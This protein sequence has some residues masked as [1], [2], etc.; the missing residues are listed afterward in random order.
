MV[1][2]DLTL[3]GLKK[4]QLLN[5]HYTMLLMRHFEEKAAEG[6]T[7]GKIGGF[8]HLYTG[9]EAVGSGVNLALEQNDVV[10]SSYREHGHALAK[11][12]DPNALMAELYGRASGV[13]KGRGGSM[14]I[15]SKEHKLFGGYAIVAAQLPIACGYA[16]SAK[17]LKEN[18]V[19]VVYFG[20]GA[21]DEGAFH[22]ALNLA[23]VWQ[24]PV[25]F[26]CENNLYSMGMAVERAW[27]VSSLEPRAKAYAMDYEQ[28]NGMNVLDVYQTA[29]KAVKRARETSMPTLIEA[30]TYRFRGHSMAD[31]SSYRSK[32]EAEKWK[33]T[34]DPI[35]LF[36]NALREAGIA[37]NDDFKKNDDRALQIATKA[38]E[39]ADK[40]PMP[41]LQ[42]L[43]EDIM[44]DPTGAIAWRRPR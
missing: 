22:E 17:L 34:S 33:Q 24:L 13:S 44:V 3:A 18:F 19:T 25:V 30:K 35:V 12:V 41:E 26:V 20:D 40:S 1:I 5:L 32:E 37:N 2:R 23:Q 9:Q 21:V 42:S 14:H 8:L 15:F 16:L 31:P 4:E 11:G 27:A 39:F 29:Q 7:L 38:V 36:E 10:I 28:V 43:T 6:Y